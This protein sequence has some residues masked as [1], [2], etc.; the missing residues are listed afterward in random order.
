[1]SVCE[2]LLPGDAL[3]T[4]AGSEHERAQTRKRAHTHTV[5]TRHT[6]SSH[7]LL[8]MCRLTPQLAPLHLYFGGF[9][10]VRYIT[11]SCTNH[12]SPPTH[13]PPPHTRRPTHTPAVRVLLD[14]IRRC[15]GNVVIPIHFG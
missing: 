2:R 13:A 10:F 5:K 1:M 14:R 4:H 7:L 11:A 12:P 6:S 8:C 9:V 15:G 3:P